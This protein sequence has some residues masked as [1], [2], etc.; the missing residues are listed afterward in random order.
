MRY[1]DAADPLAVSAAAAVRL[2]DLDGVRR[3]LSGHPGLARVRLG[4]AGGVSRTLLHVLTDWPGHV[5]GGPALVREL[6]AAGAEVDARF[7]GPHAETPLM[8]AASCDDVPVLDAL[9][10]AGADVEATGAVI[11]GGTALSD[12]CAFA[13][14]DA[15]RRLVERGAS[16]RLWE[17]A[18]LGL[19]DRVAAAF[20]AGT[21]SRAEVTQGLWAACHGGQ[22][23][24]AAFL[25]ERGGDLGWV[26]YDEL[27][28]L[29]AARRAG[30]DDLVSWLTARG[31][32]PG[33][34]HPAG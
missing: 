14:W 2:G 30:A 29:D 21:P 26:G 25:L 15:A 27:T 33:P 9:L 8:W 7:A 3:L 20:E 28:P 17:A 16:A 31:A 24:A 23:Q 11:G 34:R 18:A 1:L 12:A 6:V 22:S 10:D 19:M 13:Q 4:E 5:P 32:R